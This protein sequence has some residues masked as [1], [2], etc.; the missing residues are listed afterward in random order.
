M[1]P[2]VLQLLFTNYWN[3]AASGIGMMATNLMPVAYGLLAITFLMGVY[4][5]FVSGPSLKQL[6]IVVLKY[7][8]ASGIVAHWPTFMNDVVQASTAIGSTIL[9]G[10]SDI[11]QQWQTNISQAYTSANLPDLLG[12]GLSALGVGIVQVLIIFVASALFYVCLKLLAFFFV[13]WGA[14]LYCLGPFMVALAPSG[15]TG[16]YTRTYI[17]GLVEWSMWPVIYCLFVSLMTYINLGST[18]TILN[19]GV[20]GTLAI[21]DAQLLAV[22][23]LVF[24][25]CLLIIPFIAHFI[26]GANFSKAFGAAVGML[27]MASGNVNALLGAGASSGGGSQLGGSRS[28]GDSGGIGGIG[29]GGSRPYVGAGM[30]NMPPTPSAIS[31]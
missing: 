4:E 26:I 29:G 27:S 6:S 3:Q 15:I 13:L 7:A 23:S 12:F 31:T 1:V 5:S 9:N 21:S 22:T 24:G 19:G 17:K 18:G 28:G 14:V 8:L 10:N 30:G 11:F 2:G 25:I 20:T 16:D